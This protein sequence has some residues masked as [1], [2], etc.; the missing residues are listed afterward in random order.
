MKD[1]MSDRINCLSA[2]AQQLLASMREGQVLWFSDAGEY[3]DRFWLES[4]EKD[5]TPTGAL[6]SIKVVMELQQEGFIEP[7][8]GDSYRQRWRLV[9]LVE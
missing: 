4:P 6:A 2:E 5:A 3:P 8:S 9:G 1:E 7:D